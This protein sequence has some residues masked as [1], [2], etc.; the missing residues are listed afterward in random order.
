MKV[1]ALGLFQM[2]VCWLQDE[3][4]LL[5]DETSLLQDE[6]SLLQ[7]SRAGLTSINAM[8]QQGEKA[9]ID[10]SSGKCQ[11]STSAPV[12]TT[13][14]APPMVAKPKPKPKPPPAK[15]LVTCTAAGDADTICKQLQDGGHWENSDLVSMYSCL[16][17][18]CIDQTG[19]WDGVTCEEALQY[20]MTCS[21]PADVSGH[22]SGQQ[23]TKFT[24]TVADACPKMCKE[25]CAKCH[26]TKAAK[27]LAWVRVKT[28]AYCGEM[29][30]ENI[31]GQK[32]KKYTEKQCAA[33]AFD[34]GKQSFIL[35]VSYRRG[36]CIGGT[37][38]VSKDLY[39]DWLE[40]AGNPQCVGDWK[41][42]MLFDFYALE[43]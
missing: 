7:V 36:K 38:E 24:G 35:G 11:H 34:A 23:I 18:N 13:T 2:A 29:K 40:S 30:D 27:K 43:P 20:G 28:G 12:P 3:T 25:E 10:C 8:L 37:M 39:T 21:D 1:L 4:S 31:L 9:N 26:A 32:R 6:T 42:T 22:F 41:S 14:A 5:Q 19:L 16:A 17:E 33:L 15:P